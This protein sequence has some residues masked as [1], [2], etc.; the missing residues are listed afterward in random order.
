MFALTDGM[1]YYLCQHYV[2]TSLLSERNDAF[3]SIATGGWN[4]LSD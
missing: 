3:G 4:F 1:H 2:D